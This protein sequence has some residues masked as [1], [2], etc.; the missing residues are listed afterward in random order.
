MLATALPT[1]ALAPAALSSTLSTAAVTPT[2]FTATALAPTSLTPTAGTVG[3][4]CGACPKEK[5]MVHRRAGPGMI[6]QQEVM[7]ESKEKCKREEKTLSA[8]IE[9][10]GRHLTP[11]PTTTYF[12]THPDLPLTTHHSPPNP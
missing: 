3:R 4:E 6:V 8:T 11:S 12:A 10:V 1:A 2:S 5:K 7:V 9:K